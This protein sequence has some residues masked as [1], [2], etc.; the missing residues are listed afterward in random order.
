MSVAIQEQ[1]KK[2]ERKDAEE[3]EEKELKS[4]PSQ[5]KGI[6]TA[7]SEDIRSP[8]EQL[9]VIQANIEVKVSTPLTCHSIAF[10]LQPPTISLLPPN[11]AKTP[12]VFFPITRNVHVHIRYG[13]KPVS[14]ILQSKATSTLSKLAI[15]IDKA[16]PYLLR[17]SYVEAMLRLPLLYHLFFIVQDKVSTRLSEKVEELVAVANAE[18][19]KDFN[20]LTL[21]FTSDKVDELRAVFE[22][23]VGEVIAFIIPKLSEKDDLWYPLALAL[24][25]FYHEA[26]GRLPETL[27]FTSDHCSEFESWLKS[28][29][30]FSRRITII[31]WGCIRNSETVKVFRNRLLETLSQDLGFIIM[32]APA[33]IIMKVE[34]DLVN[35][36]APHRLKVVRIDGY[37]AD[38]SKLRRLFTTFVDIFNISTSIDTATVSIVLLPRLFAEADRNYKDFIYSAL[39]SRALAYV[40][41]DV[42]EEES[43]DHVAMKAQVIDYLMKEFSVKPEAI[44]VTHKLAEDVVA[45]IYIESINGKKVAIECETL[46]G[47]GAAPILKIF[48]SVRKYANLKYKVDEVWV[49]VRTWGSLLH[50]GNL[51]WG[52]AILKNEMKEKGIKVKFYT[53]NI[54]KMRLEPLD[55]IL[56]LIT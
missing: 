8:A 10:P 26:K 14:F 54:S 31:D 13:V 44:H 3:H 18:K 46:F 53:I 28:D 21:M 12:E 50:L 37:I 17:L 55:S 11:I 43:E 23:P 40:R 41:R 36:S 49:V 33:G 35:I 2:D 24:R 38:E 25:E 1:V 27:M 19:V 34:S 51:I 5:V 52:E 9:P 42:S 30:R 29:G 56:R 4:R 39:R 15:A 47:I 48:E 7:R 22:N 6:G 16:L 20:I 32:L 45:D